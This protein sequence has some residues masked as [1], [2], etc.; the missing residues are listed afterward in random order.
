MCEIYARLR[1]RLVCI[2][3]VLVAVLLNESVR[4]ARGQGDVR[5]I[6]DMKPTPENQPVFDWLAEEDIC[7]GIEVPWYTAEPD[8]RRLRSR[9]W[10]VLVHLHAHPETLRRHWEYK[11]RA[12]PEVD[13]V[14]QKHINAADGRRDRVNW[15]MFI[16]DDSCGV[17]HSQEVLRAKPKTHAQARALLD[18]HL[19]LAG[20][21]AATYPEL[22]KWGMCGFATSTHAFAAHGL[23]WLILERANDDVD[24]LQTGIAFARGA[25]RQYGCHWG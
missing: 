17:G 18:R 24:D 7:W 10:E 20:V 14:L 16:E 23:D 13:A 8:I 25:V 2:A 12:V 21:V 1:M 3:W 9:G 4:S 5:I 22:P 15:L 6:F 19:E 11:G